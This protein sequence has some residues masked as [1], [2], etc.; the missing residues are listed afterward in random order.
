MRIYIHHSLTHHSHTWSNTTSTGRLTHSSLTH[1][2][3]YDE[4]GTT[5]QKGSHPCVASAGRQRTQTGGGRSHPSSE[6]EYVHPLDAP[7]CAARWRIATP[8]TIRPRIP[9]DAPRTTYIHI[10]ICRCICIHIYLDVCIYIY[11]YMCVWQYI[12]LNICMYM[13]IYICV[14]VH[15]QTCRHTYVDITTYT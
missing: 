13:Y 12:G 6:L 9:F 7:K 10:Y 15:R 14:Y 11:I 4:Y 3:K 2:V 5:M 1:V 8:N